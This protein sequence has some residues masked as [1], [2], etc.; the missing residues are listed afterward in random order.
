M[1][2]V[3]S[4]LR[5]AAADGFAWSGF[6]ATCLRRQRPAAGAPPLDHGIAIAPRYERLVGG[7]PEAAATSF[8]A[9]DLIRV[10]ITVRVPES[11]DFLAVTDPLPAGF[12]AVDTTLAGAG[13]EADAGAR[14]APSEVAYWR[15]GFDRVQRYD[16]RVDLFA[17]SLDQGL[18]TVTY[19]AQATTP[20]TFFAAP[21][22]AEAM[23]EP[24]VA[25]RRAGATIT[26]TATP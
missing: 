16:D 7:Q 15:R 17:T 23:Y 11:R 2:R 24:K 6:Y 1:A 25:G 4:L 9:G 3:W 14:T 26:V 21:T 10:T 18:H 22:Q 5:T 19:L 12:E 8:A 13:D 20:G